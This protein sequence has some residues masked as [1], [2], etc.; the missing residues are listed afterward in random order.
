VDTT[1]LQQDGALP[2]TANVAFEVLH[3]VFGSRV[4]SN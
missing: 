4:L 2:H 1:F 3:D